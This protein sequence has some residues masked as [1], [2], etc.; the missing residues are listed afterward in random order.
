MP[1]NITP[2]QNDNLVWEERLV[3][4]DGESSSVSLRLKSVDDGSGFSPDGRDSS[5]VSWLSFTTTENTLQNSALETVVT[6]T[7]DQSAIDSSHTYRFQL[8]A[9]DGNEV[10]TRETDLIVQ[11]QETRI[12]NV[13]GQ[14]DRFRQEGGERV[15]EGGTARV[16]VTTTAKA[17]LDFE[18]AISPQNVNNPTFGQQLT[19]VSQG[20]RYHEFSFDVRADTLYAFRLTA[21]FGGTQKQ[22]DVFY[23]E[24][25]S[26]IEVGAS[27]NTLSLP[28]AFAESFD[29]GSF[30]QE[31]GSFETGSGFSE[32]NIITTSLDSNVGDI[33]ITSFTFAAD[34]V[35]LGGS[36][37]FETFSNNQVV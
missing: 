33:L 14:E 29:S 12:V 24:T 9:D 28:E 10:S 26:D 25:G 5:N 37:H 16:I 8:L 11:E 13:M 1:R 18:Y 27:R 19:D 3:N 17:D 2:N 15:S 21:K 23:L 34:Q 7:A 31:S 6:I 35:N 36:S 32:A 22:S 30:V 4:S 20:K